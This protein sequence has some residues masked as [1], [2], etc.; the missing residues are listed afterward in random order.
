[1]NELKIF[2]NAEFGSVRT[3]NKDGEPWFIGKDIA[4]IL[5]YCNPRDAL[6]KHVDDEDKANVAI[7]DGSQNRNMTIINESGL[8]SLVLSSKMPEAK[9]FKRWVT[10]EVLPAIR[11]T[12]SYGGAA[13]PEEIISKTVTAVVSEVIKQIIPVFTENIVEENS[14][15]CLIRRK[16]P[17]G[18]IEKLDPAI[19]KE[20]EEMIVSDRYS[21]LDVVH[22]IQDIGVDISIT[23]VWRY[24]NKMRSTK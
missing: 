14:D 2:E 22:Y 15:N 24:A 21:Y 9:K 5:G 4:L 1:M 17:R 23:S 12:G 6:S 8:Y 13:N 20:I 16:R 3:I 10:S 18:T 11:K 19:I 7:H